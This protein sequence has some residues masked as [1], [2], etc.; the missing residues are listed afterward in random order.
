MQATIQCQNEM[1][2]YLKCLQVLY[3]T[4]TPLV[5]WLITCMHHRGHIHEEENVSNIS[6]LENDLTI[7]ISPVIAKLSGMLAGI[8]KR[9]E[10]AGL[11]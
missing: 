1:K 3:C 4:H 10:G 11:K 8:S 7:C 2:N 9:G 6:D 5:G